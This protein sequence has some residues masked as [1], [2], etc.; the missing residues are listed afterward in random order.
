MVTLDGL[1]GKRSFNIAVGWKILYIAPHSIR[2]AG[3]HVP[4]Y[5]YF[6]FQHLFHWHA[7]FS[8]MISRWC[9]HTTTGLRL[10]WE[11]RRPTGPK[12]HGSVQ[13]WLWTPHIPTFRPL[14]HTHVQSVPTTKQKYYWRQAQQK[15]QTG[16]F[17]SHCLEVSV[18]H[19]TGTEARKKAGMEKCLLDANP[20]G[21]GVDERAEGAAACLQ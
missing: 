19:F 12:F 15:F 21:C 7:G 3:I 10:G 11:S 14:Q 20:I 2:T 16:L 1:L 8:P 18:Y 6:L 13:T 9:Y 17:V 4:K 5:I